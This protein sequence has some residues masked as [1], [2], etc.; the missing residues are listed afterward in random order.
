MFLHLIA[1]VRPTEAWTAFHV[2]AVVAV[3]IAT[4]WLVRFIR[5]RRRR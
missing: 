5:V 3:A 2:A 1:T 4:V